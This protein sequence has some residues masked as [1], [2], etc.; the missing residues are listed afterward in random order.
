MGGLPQVHRP[1]LLKS[2]EHGNVPRAHSCEFG[3]EAFVKC[4]QTLTLC[5]RDEAVHHASKLTILRRGFGAHYSILTKNGQ[6]KKDQK[7]V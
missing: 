1:Q 3:N 4:E 5:C 6:N 7:S 2:N